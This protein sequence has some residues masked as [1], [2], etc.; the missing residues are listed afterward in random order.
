MTTSGVHPVV[1]EPVLPT[2]P[3]TTTCQCDSSASAL[4]SERGR[5]RTGHAMDE[6]LDAPL[7]TTSRASHSG[8]AS[9]ITGGTT[10]V[11]TRCWLMCTKYRYCS[12]MSCTG[13]SAATHSRMMPNANHRFCARGDRRLPGG[14]HLRADD[15]GRVHVEGDEPADQHPHLG[16][17]HPPPEVHAPGGVDSDHVRRRYLKK[18]VVPELEGRRA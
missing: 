10:S 8:V 3:L 18:L 17:R 4:K 9:S 13:Q 6:A 1:E 14:H 11:S 12:P 15:A 5:H 7:P 2:A 16:V